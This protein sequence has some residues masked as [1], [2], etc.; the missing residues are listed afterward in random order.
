M[1]QT[2]VQF[3][4]L[5]RAQAVGACR[6][7]SVQ[8]LARETTRDSRHSFAAPARNVGITWKVILLLWL[9]FLATLCL[10]ASV[11]APILKSVSPNPLS[12]G[13]AAVAIKASGLSIRHTGSPSRTPS[14]SADRQRRSHQAF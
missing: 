8:F 9:L 1:S 12:A 7:R 14:A 6:R 4:P 13:A 10:P 3:A 5:E 11:P 2:S